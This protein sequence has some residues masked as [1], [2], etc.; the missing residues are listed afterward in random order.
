MANSD[1]VQIVMQ[2]TRALHEW[3]EQNQGVKL[4]LEAA[5]LR[6]ATLSGAPL[7]EA[8]L[9]GLDLGSIR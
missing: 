8:N 6:G 1:H 4:D 9:Q 3:R 7:Q 5:D 2:G